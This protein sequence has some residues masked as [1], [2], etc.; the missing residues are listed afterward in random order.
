MLDSVALERR[1]VPTVAIAHD[2]FLPAAK[3]QAAIA[4]IADIPIV[5][6]PRPAQGLSAV[7]IADGDPTLVERVA[8]AL[9]MR[10]AASAS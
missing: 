8:Q 6:T 5:D 2:L 9:L 4:G 7:Q 1:G 10:L 3:L